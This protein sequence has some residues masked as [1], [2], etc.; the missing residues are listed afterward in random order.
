MAV[1]LAPVSSSPAHRQQW[2]IP[3]SVPAAV[4]PGF[5]G[6]IPSE[7]EGTINR[8]MASYIA[9]LVLD[10]FIFILTF[11]RAV[12]L[13]L[14]NARIPLVALALRD[15]T[16]YFLCVLPHHARGRGRVI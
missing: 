9:A 11:S 4:P 14:L 6:C 16:M 10:S 3:A 5:V 2:S 7:K 15:G 13:R 8:L 12:H 1:R